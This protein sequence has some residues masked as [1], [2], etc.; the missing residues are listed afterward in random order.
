MLA[1]ALASTTTAQSAAPWQ[2]GLITGG[3][4]VSWWWRE[5]AD[6]HQAVVTTVPPGLGRAVCLAPEDEPQTCVVIVRVGWLR[7]ETDGVLIGERVLLPVV[8]R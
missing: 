1:L 7:V 4:G 2:V 8:M 6:G 5:Q 3:P